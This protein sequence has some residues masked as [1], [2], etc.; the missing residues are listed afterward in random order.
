MN[1][2]G[3]TI[4]HMNDEVRPLIH[5]PWPHNHE[6]T[7]IKLKV[8]P[9]LT[10]LGHIHLVVGPKNHN[11]ALNEDLAKYDRNEIRAVRLSYQ[12]FG[13]KNDIL[14]LYPPTNNIQ[15]CAT[16]LV[17]LNWH[18][19]ISSTIIKGRTIVTEQEH[20]EQSSDYRCAL[21]RTCLVFVLVLVLLSSK[22]RNAPPIMR[23]KF[24]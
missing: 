22:K 1:H 20:V 13:C 10:M 18:P 11:G 12:N 14:D 4:R 16:M 23:T 2:L 8:G 3:L 7:S 19:F 5:E 21:W 24:T 6:F 15:R 17:L 9:W